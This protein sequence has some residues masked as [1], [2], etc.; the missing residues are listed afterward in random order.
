MAIDELVKIFLD[1]S[2]DEIR[3]LEAGLIKLEED[4]SDEGT[5]NRVF[6]AAHTIKGSAGLVGFDEVSNFTH[7][8]ENIL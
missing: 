5:I 4:Q 3:E 6:R 7:D 1:E 2:E 8:L